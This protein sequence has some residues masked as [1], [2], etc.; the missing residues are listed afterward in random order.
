MTLDKQQIDLLEKVEQNNI[1][2]DAAYSDDLLSD[3][4]FKEKYVHYTLSSNAMNGR[5]QI[6]QLYLTEKGKVELALALETQHQIDDS[7]RKIILFIGGLFL[8]L[9]LGKLVFHI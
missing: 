7:N 3:L 4:V 2:P 8:G 9:V 5:Y 6:K 1:Q